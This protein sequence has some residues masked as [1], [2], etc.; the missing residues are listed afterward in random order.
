MN[1]KAKNSAATMPIKISFIAHLFNL[2]N[3]LS[4]KYTKK[5]N[6][7]NRAIKNIRKSNGNYMDGSGN[8]RTTVGNYPPK[9]GNYIE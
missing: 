9:I 4:N 1:V 8:Y 5:F 6:E 2:K 7:I 3:F